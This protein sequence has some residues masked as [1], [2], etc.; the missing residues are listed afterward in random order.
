MV[1][2]CDPLPNLDGMGT[3]TSSPSTFT[4]TKRFCLDL[5]SDGR[6]SPNIVST[7]MSGPWPLLLTILVGLDKVFISI[8]ESN[9]EDGTGFYLAGYR[10]SLERLGI[11]HE[12]VPMVKDEG[13]S[14]PYTTSLQRIEFLAKL[15]NKTIGPIQSA[16]PDTRLANWRELTRV[17]FL[18]DI[19]FEW[20]DIVRLMATRVKGQENE[21][22]DVACAMDFGEYGEFQ[23]TFH[24]YELSDTRLSRHLGGLRYNVC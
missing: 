20:E 17:I 8:Y 5:P 12:V 23:P 15:R 11:S 24:S 4:T 19:R 10:E 18:N 6:L 16:D 14:W 9:S 2:R 21:D 13:E 22:Y 3:N 7:V 1:P